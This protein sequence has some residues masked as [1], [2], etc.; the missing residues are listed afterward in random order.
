M[1]KGDD[2]E[3]FIGQWTKEHISPIDVYVDLDDLLYA[4]T[5]RSD[6]LTL[7]AAQKGYYQRLR[8]MAKPYGGVVQY[9]MSLFDEASPLGSIKKC[10]DRSERGGNVVPATL[11]T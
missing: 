7:L 3:T 8:K 5:Q 10:P 6:H 2:F 4:A 1:T 11:S 9:V